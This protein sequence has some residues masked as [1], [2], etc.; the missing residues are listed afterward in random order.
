QASLLTGI[1]FG[2]KATMP[3]QLYNALVAT[4]TLHIIALS[5]VNISILTSLVARLTLFLGRKTSSL[6]SVCVIVLF[7][8]FVG[9]S[10]SIVRAAIMGSFSLIGIYFGRY[11]F[12]VLSFIFASVLMLLY[13]FS[14][15]Y[16]LSFQL[17]FLA[18]FGIILA[19]KKLERQRKKTL[20]EKLLFPVKENFKLTLSAQLF[21]L[22]VILYNF[23]RLSLI[24]PLANLMIE[25]TIQPIMILG[26]ITAAAGW[27]WQPLGIIPAWFTWVPLAYLIGVVEWLAKI[28]GASVRF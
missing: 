25:W 14:L 15:I 4:G 16:N 9:A 2:I 26:F 12:V 21:T 23:R 28:P 17:S 20:L 7:V 19:N 18:T 11:R 5:G 10:P 1:L 8:W 13:D 3:R 6:V 22:P 27:I 24:A